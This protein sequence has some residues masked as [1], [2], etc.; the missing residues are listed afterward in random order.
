MKRIALACAALVLLLPLATPAAAHITI[1][2]GT[3]VL[4][5]DLIAFVDQGPAATIL[6]SF[7][8]GTNDFAVSGTTS[9][10][11][12]QLVSTT[13][14][15]TG[16]GS[17]LTSATFLVPGS[18]LFNDFLFNLVG[19]P[20]T[21]GQMTIT[22]VGDQG[23]GFSNNFAIGNGNNVF[24]VEGTAGESIQSVTVT[25]LSGSILSVRGLRALLVASGSAVPEPAS[26]ALMLLGF[27]AIGLAARRRVHQVSRAGAATA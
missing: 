18:G 26:W 24:T 7:G 25:A 23:G 21:E 9:L 6:G 1:T 13:N 11:G 10:G 12:S 3:V 27:A 22:I 5:N 4:P 8:G 15:I 14:V 19:G 2:A 16:S 20:G 17:N